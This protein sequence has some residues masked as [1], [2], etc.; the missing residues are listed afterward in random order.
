MST[1]TDKWTKIWL[2]SD[3]DKILTVNRHLSLPYPPHHYPIRVNKNF[4]V[5]KFQTKNQC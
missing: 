4:K 3:R 5:S 1:L 2:I